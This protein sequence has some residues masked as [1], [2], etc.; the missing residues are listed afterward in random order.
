MAIPDRKR[1]A[2]YFAEL[3]KI[4]EHRS[5]TAEKRIQKLYKE[6][7][8]NL[9][10]FLG[11]EYAKYAEDDKLTYATLAK[12]NEYAKFLEEVQKKING[13]IP[14]VNKTITETV[15]EMYDTAYK[16]IVNAVAKSI[17]DE[18]LKK[19]FSGIHLTQ[20]QV[21]KAAVN[22]PISKLTLS[23]TLEKNRKQIVYNIKSTVTNGIMNGDTMVTMANKI[24]NDVDQNY[25]KAM[26]ITRTEVHR[27][28]ETGHND[29]SGV[30][31]EKL[32]ESNSQYRMVK[33]WKS[34]QDSSVRFTKLADHRKMHG[35]VVLQD[36]DFDLG[37][38]V[39]APCPCQ[40]GKA[41]HDCN[42][43]CRATRDLW[44]DEEFFKAT[45]RHFP[46]AV[47]EQLNSDDGKPI[48]ISDEIKQSLREY[49]SGKYGYYCEYSQAL[50]SKS[51]VELEETVKKI[52]YYTGSGVY[53]QEMGVDTAKKRT[54]EIMDIIASQ[55]VDDTPLYRIDK[56]G[57]EHHEGDVFSWGI[58]STSRDADFADKVLNGLDEGLISY[59]DKLKKLGK[60]PIVYE[61]QGKKKHLD[62]STYSEYDQQESLI[63]GKFRVISVK[64]DFVEQ[65][66]LKETFEE[67]LE[68]YPQKFEFFTSK[69]GKEM[70]RIEGKNTIE[71]ASAKTK[72]F[73]NGNYNDSKGEWDYEREQNRIKNAPI[74][75]IIEQ[76][77]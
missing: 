7:L 68:K 46:N 43:R 59:P 39:K 26:L 34:K 25:R 74:R 4:E 66:I 72:V 29:A 1:L 36:E 50:V 22:N 65:T 49:T 32:A 31:D 37:N 23:K 13:I 51:G 77:D 11:T 9:Q 24:K 28:R 42:C 16:G 61:I 40:T 60:K 63:Y 2:R 14:S 33:I 48:A 17:N 27:V 15:I 62:I 12:K 56:W 53:I 19:L 8:K 58:H 30:L 44:S 76:I 54:K 69:K 6:M 21:L 70:V 3:Q 71:V 41:Y 38:G 18:E 10:G 45:G 73:Y 67:A 35:Q 55:P 20:A 52:D 5:A 47:Q 57:V 64:Q 75:V